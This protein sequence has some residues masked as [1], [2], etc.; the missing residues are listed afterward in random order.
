MGLKHDQ[1]CIDL[2]SYYFNII[3][4]APCSGIIF[5]IIV[6]NTVVI[7]NVVN[8]VSISISAEIVTK[9]R[10]SLIS[11]LQKAIKDGHQAYLKYI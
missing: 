11:F 10:S 4:K 6:I 7:V 3:F 9:D 8:F 2:T 1:I 5:V